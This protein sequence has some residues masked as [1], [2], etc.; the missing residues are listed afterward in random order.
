MSQPWI[1]KA[2][3][4]GLRTRIAAT[5]GGFAVHADEKLTA[6]I[7]LESEISRPRCSSCRTMPV[8]RHLTFP[9]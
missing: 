3:Q 6:S 2:A 5:E 1:V 7:E 8:R 9:A 4:S